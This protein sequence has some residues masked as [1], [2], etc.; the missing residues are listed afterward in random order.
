MNEVQWT[1]LGLSIAG[2]FAA[3]GIKNLIPL[4]LAELERER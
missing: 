1:V 2:V 3:V 4:V